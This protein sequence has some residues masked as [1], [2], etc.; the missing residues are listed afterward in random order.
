MTAA[1]TMRRHTATVL[2]LPS[3]AT[4]GFSVSTP[5]CERSAGRSSAA[6]APPTARVSTE[7]TAAMAASGPRRGRTNPSIESVSSPLA[8]GWRNASACNQAHM[9]RE[10][11]ATRVQWHPARGA[12]ARVVGSAEREGFEPS[13]RSSPP[14]RF[15][16]ALLRPLGHLS[17]RRRSYRTGGARFARHGAAADGSKARGTLPRGGVAER[18][19]AAVSKT[20]S[21]FRLR[22]GFKSLPLRSSPTR[23]SGARGR[24]PVERVPARSPTTARAGS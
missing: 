21:G 14:T 1:P 11:R 19:N 15:P 18:S 12:K 5:A 4:R 2:P 8:P 20:V 16:G 10:F 17:R 24:H 3:I 9:L 13:R 6:T 22:R 23:A 7:P